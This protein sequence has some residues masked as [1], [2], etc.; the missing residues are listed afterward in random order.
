MRWAYFKIKYDKCRISFQ[1]LTFEYTHFGLPKENLIDLDKNFQQHTKQWK[2]KIF[3]TPYI[4]V[5]SIYRSKSNQ[6]KYDPQ[7]ALSFLIV[8]VREV[9]SVQ[10]NGSWEEPRDLIVGLFHWDKRTSACKKKFKF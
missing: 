5:W 6:I 3:I 2:S 4:I 1:L 9:M 8:A 10:E 7:P